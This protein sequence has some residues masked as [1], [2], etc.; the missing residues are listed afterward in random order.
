MK[1]PTLVDSIVAKAGL[2]PTDTVLEIGSGTGN[3]TKRL[4]EAGVKA[5]VA[6]ELDPHMVLELNRRFQEHPLSSCLEC[7][8]CKPPM[9]RVPFLQID[10]KLRF[11]IFMFEGVA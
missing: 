3:L 9:F 1:N 7:Q 2:K 5:V 4:L 10:R 8:I 11:T 6:V